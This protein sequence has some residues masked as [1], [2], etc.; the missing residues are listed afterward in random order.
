M[1]S[2]TYE[3]SVEFKVSEPGRFALRVEGK[4]PTSLRPSTLA[5]VSAQNDTRGELR[6]RL[7][8]QNI[9]TAS[10]ILGRPLFLDY[11]TQEGSEGV[12]AGALGIHRIDAA[13]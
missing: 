4:A 13:R 1:N 3:Q 12:P 7:L 6:P 2:S 8:I 11:A 5:S 10:R 9:D